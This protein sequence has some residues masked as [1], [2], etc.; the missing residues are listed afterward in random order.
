VN[1][2]PFTAFGQDAALALDGMPESHDAEFRNLECIVHYSANPL[3]ADFIGRGET[4]SMGEPA[5]RC[6]RISTRRDQAN[7]LT[8]NQE[9]RLEDRS[10]MPQ[11]LNFPST[12]PSPAVCDHPHSS[13]DLPHHR[14]LTC[15]GAASLAGREVVGQSLNGDPGA[16]KDASRP[17][18]PGCGRLRWSSS[19]F[20]RLPHC[21]HHVFGAAADALGAVT[22]LRRV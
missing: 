8:R 22:V 5:G 20:L 17:S 11:T 19:L 1:D 4:K 9:G 21:R 12:Y 14:Q 2:G 7:A 16:A 15:S 13:A 18:H 6:V 10:S 3:L